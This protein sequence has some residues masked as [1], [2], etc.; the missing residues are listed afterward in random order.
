MLFSG[1]LHSRDR[2]FQDLV[3][4]LNLIS[5]RGRV[6]NDGK[7]RGSLPFHSSREFSFFSLS[8]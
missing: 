1:A 7:A 4:G 8:S 2:Y 6:V 3:R 5:K